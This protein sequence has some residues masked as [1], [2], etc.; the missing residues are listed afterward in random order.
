MHRWSRGWIPTAIHPLASETGIAQKGFFGSP[1]LP[2]PNEEAA[3]AVREFG[4]RKR[5]K[6]LLPFSSW[7]PG[8]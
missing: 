5:K 7:H 3:A 8:R 2:S 6:F 4:E 1:D